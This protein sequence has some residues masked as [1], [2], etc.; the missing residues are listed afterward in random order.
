MNKLLLP[1]D[2]EKLSE[3]TMDYVKEF[4][5]TQ[6]YEVTI[7]Y[8]IPDVEGHAKPYLA[9]VYGLHTQVFENAANELVKKVELQL[10]EAGVTQIN[11]VVT[12]GHPAAEIVKMA[13]GQEF[14]LIL[15]N[16]HG[17]DVTKRFM[18]G[19]VTNKVLHNSYVPVLVIP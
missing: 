18:L 7:L 10:K 1:V 15:M 11:S 6:G 9:T 13:E 4:A 16:T 14:H 19:S 8:V 2:S 12:K 3:R 17:L 5:L